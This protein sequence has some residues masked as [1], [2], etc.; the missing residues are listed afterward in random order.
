MM[1]QDRSWVIRTSELTVGTTLSFDLVDRQGR[2][3]LKAGIPYSEAVRN[4]LLEHGI[5]TVTIKIKP[6]LPSESESI[7]LLESYEP[8]SVKRLQS[9]LED[10]QQ[11]LSDFVGGIKAGQ[12]VPVDSI[13]SGLDQF[14]IEAVRDVATALGVIA[15]SQRQ[16][17]KDAF[18][19]LPVRSTYL[20]WYSMIT[21]IMMGMDANDISTLG[22]AGALHD[23]SLMLHPEWLDSEYRTQHAKKFATEYQRHPLESAEILSASSGVN[24]RIVMN[25]TQVHEQMDGSGYPRGLRASQILPTARILN[26]VDAYLEI[27]DPLFR[28][29][30]VVPADALA[31]LC[32]HAARGVFDRD[33]VQALLRATSVYPVGSVVELS[34]SKRAWVIRSNPDNPM[35]PVVRMLEPDFELADLQEWPAAIEGPVGLD[36]DGRRR[37]TKLEMGIPLWDGSVRNESA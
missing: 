10:T 23:V 34:D 7:Q 1:G 36:A 24:D 33:V 8:A 31:Q 2:V 25:V 22:L 15:V 18:A 4:R 21:G 35:Q 11:A 13:R 29:E 28:K 9:S 12:P 20:S 3:V 27:V 5:D 32:L 6:E 16:Q 14:F 37:I 19:R 30:G 17:S 26:V